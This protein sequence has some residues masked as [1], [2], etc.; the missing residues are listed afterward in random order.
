MY[1]LHTMLIMWI[2]LELFIEFSIGE[3]LELYL[4]LFCFILFLQALRS[5]YIRNLINCYLK[6]VHWF[7]IIFENAPTQIG[8]A[9]YPVIIFLTFRFSQV[10]FSVAV[11]DW[12]INPLQVLVLR[13]LRERSS[14]SQNILA[15]SFWQSFQIGAIRM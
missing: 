3:F 7:Q 15:I 8:I 12:K 13:F 14:Y 9:L 11:T 6:E 5:I 4:I 2:W 10:A 1:Y